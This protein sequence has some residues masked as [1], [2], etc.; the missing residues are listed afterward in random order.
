MASRAK[1][2]TPPRQHVR[3]VAKIKYRT[4]APEIP[5]TAFSH[6]GMCLFRSARTDKK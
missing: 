6:V 3:M 2:V 5:S 4:A 1:I